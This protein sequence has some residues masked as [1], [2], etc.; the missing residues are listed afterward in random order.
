MSI[1][2]SRRTSESVHTYDARPAPLTTDN[3]APDEEALD[4]T[5]LARGAAAAVR[6]WKGAPPETLISGFAR[7]A[8]HLGEARTRMD[9]VWQVLTIFGYAMI[10]AGCAHVLRWAA[11]F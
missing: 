1:T 2:Q 11:G 6:R 8:D 5:A 3:R 9:V 10:V 7:A 4:R